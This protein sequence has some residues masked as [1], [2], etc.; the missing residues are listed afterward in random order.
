MRKRV[1]KSPQG[2]NRVQAAGHNCP[3]SACMANAIQG[4]SS[5]NYSLVFQSLSILGGLGRV[6]VPGILGQTA[7]QETSPGS[8]ASA[9][10]FTDFE[11]LLA[12]TYVP[13]T[14]VGHARD[15]GGDARGTIRLGPCHALLHRHGGPSSGLRNSPAATR[16]YN[17]EGPGLLNAD[18]LGKG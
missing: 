16:W 1:H 10:G 18:R 11:E 2:Y 17:V 13:F 7:Q 12:Q 8:T 3:L 14:F 9:V 6:P 15:T 4:A 5:I